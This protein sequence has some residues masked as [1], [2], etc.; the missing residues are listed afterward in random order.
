MTAVP[1]ADQ[2]VPV[3][4]IS[5]QLLLDSGYVLLGLPLA[6]ASFAVLLVGLAAG[7]GLVVTV[8][9]LPILSGTLY[10]ARGLA[11]IERLRL[12]AVLHQA[13]IRPRYR[14]PEPGASA[15]RRIFVPMGDA[16]SWLDLAHGILKLIVAIVTFVVTLVWWAGAVAG[17]LYWAYDWAL[18]HGD[19]EDVGLPQLLGLGDSTIARI[20]L[21][22]AIGLFFLITLPIVARGCALLQASFGRALLT[23]VAEMRN[24]IIVLE[25]QKR[26]AVSAEASALR[27]LERDI[28]D[29]PQ[30]RLVRLA[31]DLSRAR[32]QLATDP[33]AAARTLDEAVTQTRETLAE[34]RALS[35]GI[36]PPILV[37]RGLPS[38]LAALA[39]R[40]LI[41]IELR[42]D[43][44][45][46]SPAGRLE[47]A[48]ESTA[49]FVVAEAL[50]N[51]AKHS[52]A[53]EC[54]ITVARHD[55]RLEVNV[56][57]DGQG[58][59][60]LAKGHGLVGIADRVRAA[61]GRLSVVS[62]AG[63]PTTIRAELPL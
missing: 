59:A 20:G 61:G 62:P 39:G 53:T 23:G 48:V 57:D 9:G 58:G 16:Q 60:H 34:L 21:H 19:P 5:R 55:G 45:L 47:P 52:R 36:A 7:L 14:L 27:R 32:Q 28:H 1:A 15:W 63:G 13:R 40:G 2:P 37:D 24:R 50:T 8:I 35:R 10:A 33:E 25:E 46:A 4:T 30:Q 43:P 6:L 54:Q 22:T 51:V 31:M 26:A 38:A 12:P 11:D 3:P 56:D 41:P 49:Y 29:G 42:V 18:P 44:E 17:S